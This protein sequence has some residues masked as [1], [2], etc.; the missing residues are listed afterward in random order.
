MIEA[1]IVVD[2]NGIITP[3][4][5]HEG[6]VV[7]EVEVVVGEEEEAEAEEAEEAE[8]AT[9]EVVAATTGIAEETGVVTADGRSKTSLV[10]TVEGVAEGSVIVL[11]IDVAPVGMAGLQDL[12]DLRPLWVL[13]KPDQA[14]M[15]VVLPRPRQHTRS[16]RQQHR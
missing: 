11:I 5:V 15:V 13:G 14:G 7:V 8:E 6:A 3:T 10:E 9:A 2:E 16:R 4:A 1:P 12:Q